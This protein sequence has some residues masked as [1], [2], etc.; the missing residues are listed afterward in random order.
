MTGLHEY[1]L[2]AVRGIYLSST[3]RIPRPASLAQRRQ[4][5]T[6]HFCLLVSSFADIWTFEVLYS[7]CKRGRETERTYNTQNIPIRDPAHAHII[8]IHDILILVI[9]MKESV[10][11]QIVLLFCCYNFLENNLI[12]KATS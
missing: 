1:S 12:I 6:F 10:S 2:G 8:I 11:H 7:Q 3:L 9:F 4:E 5:I